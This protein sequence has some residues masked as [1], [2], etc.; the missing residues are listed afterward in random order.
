[1]KK[2]RSKILGVQNSSLLRHAVTTI[3]GEITEPIISVES[4]DEEDFMPKMTKNDQDKAL[5]E[6]TNSILNIQLK[7]PDIYDVFEESSQDSVSSLRLIC[8]V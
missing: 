5:I 6:L 7:V 8:V 3:A 4:S 1:M 2:R